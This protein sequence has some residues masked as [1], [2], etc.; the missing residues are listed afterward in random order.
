MEDTRTTI[1][2]KI[3]C[4]LDRPVSD[5]VEPIYWI[6][7]L[8]GIGKSTIA[9]TIAE[10]AGRRNLLGASFFFSRQEKKLSDP[11]LFIPTIAYQ[12]AQ[13]YPA[14]KSVIVKILQKDPDIVENSFAT[15]IDRLILEPLRKITT[16]ES[17]PVLF[18]ADALDEC[19]NSA[20]G[21][22]RLFHAIVARCTEVPSIRLLVTSRPETYIKDILMADGITGIVLHP[23]NQHESRQYAQ[24]AYEQQFSLQDLWRQAA[25]HYEP[26]I[27][28]WG[29]AVN[30]LREE[31]N[32][33]KQR[34]SDAIVREMQYKET[35]N[36]LR[37]ELRETQADHA[38]LR[39]HLQ[40][41]D[42]EESGQIVSEFKTI[43]RT[44]EDVA[45]S[46]AEDSL[47]QWSFE[48]EGEASTADVHDIETLKSLIPQGNAVPSILF[49]KKKTPRS[50]EDILDYGLRSIIS[51]VLD[52]EIF[53]PFHPSLAS[54][55]AEEGAR[56]SGYLKELYGLT[57]S[58][59]ESIML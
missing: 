21:A 43:N 6:N 25:D 56:R 31:L 12:L 28:R 13:S 4:W 44:V 51:K 52:E 54:L 41:G 27:Q 57:R 47:R 8:A 37:Q 5:T 10:E 34:N 17:K 30:D 50:L 11:R 39:K 49:S 1:L 14:A 35:I 40:L 36:Q 48:K 16:S 24:P 18:I 59:G 29:F 15:Q 7:G 55:Q 46:A 45:R 3:W 53:F 42:P 32:I 2:E 58:Q 38:H 23:P 9:R 33:S 26:Q 19:D 22:T 20:D